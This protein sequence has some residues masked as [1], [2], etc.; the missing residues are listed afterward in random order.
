MFLMQS[1]V[2]ACARSPSLRYNRHLKEQIMMMRTAVSILIVAS[3]TLAVFSAGAQSTD[4]KSPDATKTEKAKKAEDFAAKQKAMQDASKSSASSTGTPPPAQ[5]KKS[6]LSG[7]D[8]ADMA[9]GVLQ[10]KGSKPVDKNAKAQ[11]PVKDIKTMTP[12]ERAE[13]RK[14]IVKESKP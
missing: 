14:E 3:F 8:S 7:K 2:E 4:T 11:A 13:R 12:E 10:F 5:A 1:S 9:M 6:N